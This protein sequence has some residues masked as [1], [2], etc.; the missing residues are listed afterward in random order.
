MFQFCWLDVVLV[1]Q[2]SWKG[3]VYANK[4]SGP[5]LTR[6]SAVAAPDPRQ[7]SREGDAAGTSPRPGRNSGTVGGRDRQDRPH[8][9]GPRRPTGE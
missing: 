9:K 5:V 4:V 3:F 1:T 7:R 6:V 2:C 8:R